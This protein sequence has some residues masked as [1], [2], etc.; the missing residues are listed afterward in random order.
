[1]S[2]N[3]RGKR[4]KGFIKAASLSFCQSVALSNSAHFRLCSSDVLKMLCDVLLAPALE[5]SSEPAPAHVRRIY[6]II[7]SLRLEKTTQIIQS[8]P[9]P[10][11]VSLSATSTHFMKTARGGDSTA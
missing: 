9:N 5:G 6:K 1:M 8:N 4:W 7:K 2:Q 3:Y 10:L 11:T